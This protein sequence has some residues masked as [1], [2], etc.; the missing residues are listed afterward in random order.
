MISGASD[1]AG[2]IGD[3]VRR[4]VFIRIPGVTDA[5]MH[6]AA[7]TDGRWRISVIVNERNVFDLTGHSREFVH[8][9]IGYVTAR[10]LGGDLV[11]I[12]RDP[13]ERIIALHRHW[14][15]LYELGLDRTRGKHLA[16]KYPLEEFLTIR[17]DPDVTEACVNSAT[18]QLARGSSAAFRRQ[19]RDQATDD[20]ALLAEAVT[21]LDNFAVIGTCEQ[22]DHFADAVRRRYGLVL[23]PPY[24]HY[25]VASATTIISATAARRIA[26]W[27]HLDLQLYRA[28]RDRIRGF[29]QT[30]Y[31]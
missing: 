24:G 9:Q 18:W 21:N 27:V 4:I 11:T 28:A 19:A 25:D 15:D 7:E 31:E 6:R 16:W 5:G 29:S 1:Q 3:G 8:G 12:L 17:D 30:Q 23:S 10:V 13:V 14:R 20:D 2:L 26:P 22:L